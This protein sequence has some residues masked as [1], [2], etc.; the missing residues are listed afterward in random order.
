[1]VLFIR[2]LAVTSPGSTRSCGS[3]I[4]Y[5]LTFSLSKVAFD[6]EARFCHGTLLPE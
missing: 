1:M 3:V 4:L 6:N 5:R 2:F